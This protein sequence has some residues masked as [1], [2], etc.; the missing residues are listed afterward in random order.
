MP[1]WM[2]ALPFSNQLSPALADNVPRVPEVATE[3]SNLGEAK[4]SR[5]LAVI[6]W[7]WAL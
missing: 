4:R 7:G 6:G 3:G 2:R 1:A 5:V